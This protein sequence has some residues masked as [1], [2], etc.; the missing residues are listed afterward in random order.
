MS[1]PTSDPVVWQDADEARESRRLWAVLMLTSDLEV[2]R[3]ILIG[4][5]VLARQLDAEALRRARRGEPLPPPDSYIRVRD[6]HLDGVA[7][8]GPMQPKAGGR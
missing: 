6:G 8:A 3:S 1:R 7:E 4:R 5:P 2:A